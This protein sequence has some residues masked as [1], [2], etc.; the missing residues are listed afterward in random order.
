VPLRSLAVYDDEVVLAG[1]AEVFR[2]PLLPSAAARHAVL[3]RA[4]PE[5]RTR[6]PVTV[7]V[8]R[9]AGLMLDGAT[10]FLAEPLLPGEPATALGTIAAGQLAGVLAALASV[11][12]REAQQ[13]GVAGRG[14]L[15]HGALDGSALLADPGRGV[16]SAVVGWRPRLGDPSDDLASLGAL[17]DALG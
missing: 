2:L 4:L 14:T 5:L 3:V 13:W 11:P 7:P 17:A 16:L 10:P 1:G 12:E 9:Y 15:L 6:L 8:P